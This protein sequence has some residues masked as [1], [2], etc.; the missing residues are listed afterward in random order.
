VKG[1]SVVT[2]DPGR[3][4]KIN[5]IGVT[6]TV[7]SVT[8]TR[9]V[10]VKGYGTAAMQSFDAVIVDTFALEQDASVGGLTWS[11]AV[12][13]SSVQPWRAAIATELIITGTQEVRN[14]AVTSPLKF[15]LAEN[16]ATPFQDVLQMRNG[17]AAGYSNYGVGIGYV[18]ATGTMPYP[19]FLWA[20]DASSGG[21]GLIINPRLNDTTIAGLADFNATS[22]VYQRLFN[23]QRAGRVW[24]WTTHLASLPPPDPAAVDPRL[25]VRVRQDDPW[26]AA[27][28]FAM[29]V[30]PAVFRSV[31]P[32]V[33]PTTGQ[34]TSMAAVGLGLY[35]TVF[36]FVLLFVVF[37]FVVLRADTLDGVL[38]LSMAC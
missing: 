35:V 11:V 24:V 36:S 2:D 17:S 8:V 6:S 27:L 26:R 22:L 38:S 5:H 3:A 13:T 37:C 33:S 20:D 4:M 12:S 21:G 16:G 14:A 23:R 15:W 7:S 34:A 25:P 28:R 1:R 18:A 9:N 30:S 19:L 32:A 31:Q 10:T 29:A